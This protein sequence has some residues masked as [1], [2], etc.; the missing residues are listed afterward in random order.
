M[1]SKQAWRNYQIQQRLIFHWLDSNS[2]N[3]KSETEQ[4][5]IFGEL[6]AMF[7]TYLKLKLKEENAD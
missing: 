7:I 5:R 2:F 3:V 4:E 6:E 1:T